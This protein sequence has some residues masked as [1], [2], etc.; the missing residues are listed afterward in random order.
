MVSSDWHSFWELAN[1]ARDFV[2]Y[3]PID[4]N[5]CLGDVCNDRFSDSSGMSNYNYWNS[6]LLAIGNHDVLTGTGYNWENQASITA[7]Y[8]T[9]YAPWVKQNGSVQSV[10]TTYLY[11]DFPD[12]KIRLIVLDSMTL[13]PSYQNDML[14]WF[15][16]LLDDARQKDY[17]II[18]CRHWGYGRADQSVQVWCPFSNLPSMGN[19]MLSHEGTLDSL[20]T[21]ERN[22]LNA[23]D[24]FRGNGG[25]FICHLQGHKH[26]S[27]AGKYIGF[28]HGD[29]LAIVTTSLYT[30]YGCVRTYRNEGTIGQSAFNV[31]T[32]DLD[33]ET[34]T[35]QAYG[36]INLRAGGQL[37]S[38]TF[39]WNA[40]Y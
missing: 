1:D 8:N 2:N 3:A 6:T 9:F 14:E 39:D 35:V 28:S 19:T 11:K 40:T 20:Y 4:Q 12:K 33:N 16:N 24:E 37:H 36:A 17:G 26:Y 15:K 25:K 34:V 22:I 29:Q 38:A 18:C 31:V 27:W 21:I 30:S 10:N 5:I 32:A 7:Q 23:I 13:N